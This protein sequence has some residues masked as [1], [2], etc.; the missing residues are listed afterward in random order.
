MVPSP[1]AV[2]TAG[3][4]KVAAVTRNGA[5]AMP[6]SRDFGCPGLK[7]A[8]VLRVTVRPGVMIA[9]WRYPMAAK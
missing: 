3:E 1:M 5:V 9:K 8:M 2:S 4:S 6:P 7:L